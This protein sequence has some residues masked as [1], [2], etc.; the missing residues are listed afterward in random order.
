MHVSRVLLGWSFVTKMCVYQCMHMHTVFVSVSVCNS[1]PEIVFVCMTL[2][3]YPL[4]V[5]VLFSVLVPL[6]LVVLILRTRP[7]VH[8]CLLVFPAAWLVR[9]AVLSV[10]PAGV[11]LAS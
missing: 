3:F 9:A 2:H 4:C 10:P 5:A 11:W 8:Q 7:S 1:M 6:Y